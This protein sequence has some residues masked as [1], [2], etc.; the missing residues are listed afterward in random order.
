M[1]DHPSIHNQKR[2]RGLGRLSSKNEWRRMRREERKGKNKRFGP[3]KKTQIPSKPRPRKPHTAMWK[4]HTALC[5]SGDCYNTLLQH[6]C[7]SDS[8]TIHKAPERHK[9]TYVGVW[10]LDML[11][12]LIHEHVSISEPPKSPR[13]VD[14]TILQLN[15]YKK[16]KILK[17]KLLHMH[18]K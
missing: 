14:T 9:G 1:K 11:H 16:N 2:R 17:T 18:P 7:Y 13:R 8:A 4:F 3:T 12:G 15:L 6:Y 5:L 10:L